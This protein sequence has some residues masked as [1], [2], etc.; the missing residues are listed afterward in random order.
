[1]LAKI[2]PEPTGFNVSNSSLSVLST[3]SPFQ[4]FIRNMILMIWQKRISIASAAILHFLK[5][6]SFYLKVPLTLILI[7]LVTFY[8]YRLY[9]QSFVLIGGANPV[10]VSG[11]LS[12]GD[13]PSYDFSAK[14]KISVTVKKK[15]KL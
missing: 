11:N 2:E 14:T 6:A 12:E 5:D 10:S 7:F 9:C 8:Y 4:V 1:M 15:R 13:N 3:F